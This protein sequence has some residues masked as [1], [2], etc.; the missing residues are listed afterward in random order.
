MALGTGI[1]EGNSAGSSYTVDVQEKEE[2]DVKAASWALSSLE[3]RAREKVKN[4]YVNIFV[5]VTEQLVT[6]RFSGTLCCLLTLP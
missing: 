6:T 2:G 3:G 4:T 1:E 5:R